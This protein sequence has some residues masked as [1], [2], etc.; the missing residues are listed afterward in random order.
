VAA[1]TLLSILALFIV[2]ICLI[3]NRSFNQDEFQYLH[4]GWMVSQGFVPYRDFWNNHTPLLWVLLAPLAFLFDEQPAYLFAGRLLILA[5]TIAVAVMIFRLTALLFSLYGAIFALLL[6]SLEFY[7]LDKG[8]EVRP[9]QFMI[10]S[11][12]LAVW[13]LERSASDDLSKG[14]W[15][16]GLALGIG[17]LFTPKALFAIASVGMGVLWLTLRA[18]AGP[19]GRRRDCLRRLAILGATAFLPLLATTLVLSLIGAGQA[20]VRQAFI[21]NAGFA[22][23]PDLALT[24]FRSSLI[25]TPLFWACAAIGVIL[26]CRRMRRPHSASGDRASIVMLISIAGALMAYFL[27]IPAP[28]KQSILPLVLLLA[29]A[30]GAA[31]RLLFDGLAARQRPRLRLASGA[32][33]IAIL[34]I[35]VVRAFTGMTM[36]L[37][38]LTPTNA[39]QFKRMTYVL[40]LTTKSDSVLDGQAAYVFRPQ[41][42]FYASIV[43]EL[44]YRFR[45]GGL[46]YDIPER[47]DDGGCRVAILDSRLRQMP[48]S[49][50]QFIDEQYTPTAMKE[51]YIRTLMSSQQ[52]PVRR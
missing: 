48:R 16:A 18:P 22:R 39:E 44:L 11:W 52:P 4:H 2:R 29:P 33:F 12:L 41:A 24:F 31:G 17:L 10:L 43:D 30:G 42:S 5:A 34:L 25:L 15:R 37:Q 38:P 13:F 19:S 21:D 27:I 46:A 45:T 7:A 9:D 35:G 26:W 14:T 28:Y 49:V 8:I 32:A 36:A 6:L 23:A 47:C 50:L 3:F 40:S 51:V 20:F 1:V